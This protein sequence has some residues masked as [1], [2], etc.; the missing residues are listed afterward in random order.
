MPCVSTTQYKLVPIIHIRINKTN[1]ISMWAQIKKNLK[2]NTYIINNRNKLT[3]RT[4]K[5][6]LAHNRFILK[7]ILLRT[8]SVQSPQFIYISSCSVWLLFCPGTARSRFDVAVFLPCIAN[9]ALR[10]VFVLWLLHLFLFLR[11]RIS[12]SREIEN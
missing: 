7:P 11:F 2:N 6:T 4:C 9:R 1:K 3:N 10:N 8:C 12:S 5:E